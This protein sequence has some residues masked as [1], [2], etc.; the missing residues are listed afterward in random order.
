MTVVVLAGAAL[1]VGVVVPGLAGAVPYTVL[2]GS[3]A[4]A[5]PVGSLVVAAPREAVAVGDV[6]TFQRSRDGQVVTHRVVGVGA[7]TDGRLAYTTRGDANTVADLDV[8]RPEQVHGVVW[9]HVP[10]LGR[11]A[12][13]LTGPQRQAAVTSVAA[14]LVGYAAWQVWQARRERRRGAASS[15]VTVSVPGAALASPDPRT[16]EGRREP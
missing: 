11:L 15:A 14:L 3:M 6:I 2:T 8:V 4:P 12:V 13:L 9:Y 7:S 5:I 16:A 1:L 10:H